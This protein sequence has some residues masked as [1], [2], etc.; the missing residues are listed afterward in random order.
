MPDIGNTII[1][2]ANAFPNVAE[3][4][5]WSI[6]GGGVINGST[7]NP[8][9]S[10]TWTAA[11]THTIFL[12]VGNDCSNLY[13]Q[14]NVCI[15]GWV[16]FSPET[17]K[18]GS[19]SEVQLDPCNQYKKQVETCTGNIRWIFESTNSA[20][21]GCTSTYTNTVAGEHESTINYYKNCPEGCTSV[22][23]PYTAYSLV[24]IGSVS[25]NSVAQANQNAINQAVANVNADQAANGQ[26]NANNT[27]DSIACTNC[28][29][30]T[31]SWADTGQ[32]RCNGGVSEI[33][34]GSNQCVG[35]TRWIPGGSACC[36]ET[37]TPT[38][39]TECGNDIPSGSTI[40]GASVNTCWRYREEANQCNSNTRWVQNTEDK[41][42][43]TPCVFVPTISDRPGTEYCDGTN[44]RIETIDECGNISSRLVEA[45]CTACQCVPNW[46]NIGE[47][48]C[49]G[50]DRVIDQQDGCGNTRTV[51]VTVDGCVSCVPPT[52][53]NTNLAYSAVIGVTSGNRVLPVGNYTTEDI[54]AQINLNGNITSTV[55]PA[56]MTPGTTNDWILPMV[57]I[58]TPGDVAT[59]KFWFVSDPETCNLAGTTTVI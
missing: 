56:N 33:L 20:C 40:I 45:N 39:R 58:Y 54:N 28:E 4:Y 59:L 36:T 57:W 23:I 13:T 16:D 30:V 12:H 38:G 31:T 3:G 37:W 55:I 51:I 50:N 43:C 52:E 9:V 48:Y 29:C 26:N 10:I 47:E 44:C 27:S 14:R 53:S 18:C 49:S 17:I 21:A 2:T 25:A 7:S 5:T 41:C 1:Y 6:S 19:D 8:S 15:E 34:Q 35:V 24:A 22:A 32:S 11:G 46:V 42:N